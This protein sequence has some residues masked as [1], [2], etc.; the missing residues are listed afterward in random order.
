MLTLDTAL[1]SGQGVA[2]VGAGASFT[3]TN[4]PSTSSHNHRIFRGR[5]PMLTLEISNIQQ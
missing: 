3:A 2:N 4:L 5:A 1:A